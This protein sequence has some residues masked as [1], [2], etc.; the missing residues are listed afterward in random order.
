LLAV[1][2]VV[3]NICRL[4]VHGAGAAVAAATRKSEE[5]IFSRV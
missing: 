2:D 3:P 5:F 1:A 4:I